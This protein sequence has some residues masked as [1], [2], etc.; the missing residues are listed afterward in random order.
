[1]DKQ[2]RAEILHMA[3]VKLTEAGSDE[4][5]LQVLGDV[6]DTGYGNGAHDMWLMHNPRPAKCTFTP[7][8]EDSHE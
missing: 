4:E 8:H 6:F 5:L 7:D 3:F 2:A 1:M